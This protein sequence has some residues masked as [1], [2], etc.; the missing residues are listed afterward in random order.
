MK[1]PNQSQSSHLLSATEAKA[2]W[3]YD[4]STGALVWLVK[5]HARM[6]KGS[7]A[8]TVNS[9]GYWVVTWKGKKYKTSRLAFLL[10]EGRWPD[11]EADHK[12][13]DTA[14]DRWVNLREADRSQQLTNTRVRSDNALGIKG[15]S[16]DP[17][18]GKF[19]AHIC[20]NGKR[21]N[22]GGY[23]TAAEAKAV[24]DA[25]ARASHGEFWR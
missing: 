23:S 15:V 14:D 7:R 3:S 16:L 18:E 10:M 20:K 17:R 1:Q 13:G 24:R 11:P 25:A 9:H 5:P 19:Y 2:L 8:G 12:N 22:L 6:A 4:P 21:K